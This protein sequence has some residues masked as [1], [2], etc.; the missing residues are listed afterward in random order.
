MFE[1][2]NMSIKIFT[3]CLL[4]LLRCRFPTNKSIPC[5]IRGRYGAE[6]LKLLRKSERLDLKLQ[7]A[8]LDVEF[9]CNCQDHGLIPHFLDFR[10]ANSRLRNSDAYS[11]AQR[12]FLSVEIKSRRSSVRVLEN[13]LRFVSNQLKDSFSVLDFIHTASK[14]ALTNRKLIQH[15]Q[16]IQRSKFERLQKEKS[17]HLNDPDKVI[18][19]LSSHV[20]TATQ[21]KVL[22]KGL[23][24]SVAPKKL[25]YA[26]YLT[27]FELFYRSV[28]GLPVYRGDQ[29]LIKT[30]VKEI[31]LSSLHTYNSSETPSSLSRAEHKAIMELTSV[32]DLI[33]HK[34]DKGNSVVLL[35]KIDYIRKMGTILNDPSKF[36]PFPMKRGKELNEVLKH[37][38]KL[39]SVL[40][41]IFNKGILHQDI[42]NKLVPAGSKPGRL[43][44]LSKIH[45]PG[46][47]LRP[48]LS[49]I[50]TPSYALAKFLVPI[51]APVTSNQYTVKDSFSFAKEISSIKSD[52]LFMASLDVKSLF[53]NIPLDETIEICSDALFTSEA[54]PQDIPKS[55]FKSLLRACAQKTAAGFHMGK[56]ED[57]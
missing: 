36:K 32:K 11:S 18:H 1:C 44:S 41:S 30:K 22:V 23:N 34:S 16:S 35:D 46:A 39:R 15:Q 45:K 19:N 4:F 13:Q 49:A 48:I 21:K 57:L 50:N 28:S 14:L 2:C 52:G 8:K 5:I 33:I 54:A 10:L 56:T 24:F 38:K 53:T 31:A 47:P 25:R 3:V 6:A 43:Y 51:L 17:G 37:E 55:D 9:L 7:K 12:R 20:L 42:Y 26:D 40:K 29:E 27:P